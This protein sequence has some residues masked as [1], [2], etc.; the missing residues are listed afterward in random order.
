MFWYGSAAFKY[1]FGLGEL[2]SVGEIE[3]SHSTGEQG[4]SNRDNDSFL[5]QDAVLDSFLRLHILEVVAALHAA[6]SVLA[7]A[8][9]SSSS[10][11]G[12]GAYSNC[13]GRNRVGTRLRGGVRDLT[14]RAVRE[15]SRLHSFLNGGAGDDDGDDG[16]V[17]GQCVTPEGEEAASPSDSFGTSG[18]VVGGGD[19]GESGDDCD[20]DTDDGVGYMRD[21]EKGGVF[22][23]SQQQIEA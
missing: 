6:G 16:V 18:V 12:G 4:R 22:A 7:L 1:M 14:D 23:S 15:H 17:G 5:R 8:A 21:F 10:P 9:S 20:D 13:I 2:S 19:L 11:G 3:W